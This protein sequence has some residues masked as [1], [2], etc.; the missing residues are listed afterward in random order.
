MYFPR[1]GGKTLILRKNVK[2]CKENKCL[3]FE[4]FILQDELL[5][6]LLLLLLLFNY[7]YI[8]GHYRLQI[9]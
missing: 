1:I 3:Y 5:L 8:S 6:L 7:C 4:R 2:S 9:R